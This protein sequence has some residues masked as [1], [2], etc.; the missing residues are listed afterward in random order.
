MAQLIKLKNSNGS[1][2]GGLRKDP[3]N[4]SFGL[5]CD[6]PLRPLVIAHKKSFGSQSEKGARAREIL[7]T[8]LHRLKKRT[9]DAMAAFKSAI[10]KLADQPKADPSKVLFDLDSS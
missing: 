2:T 6:E 5:I 4:S 7:M 8:V 9:P 3:S 1:V 10:D